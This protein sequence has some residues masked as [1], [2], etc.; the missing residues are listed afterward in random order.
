M[1]GDWFIIEAA[2]DVLSTAVGLF[3]ALIAFNVVEDMFR[4]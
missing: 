3:I 2:W 1:S 4:R